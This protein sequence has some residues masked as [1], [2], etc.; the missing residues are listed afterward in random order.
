MA[1]DTHQPTLPRQFLI[2]DVVD[3]MFGDDGTVQSKPMHKISLK[4]REH[5]VE[6]S[7]PVRVIDDITKVRTLLTI[8]ITRHNFLLKMREEIATLPNEYLRSQITGISADENRNLLVRGCDAEMDELT[9]TIR[10]TQEALNAI[11]FR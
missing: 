4:P 11:V 7:E 1:R 5:A 6:D 3:A 10:K 8:T 9:I 2:E